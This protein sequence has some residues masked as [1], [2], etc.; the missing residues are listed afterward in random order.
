MKKLDQA[1]AHQLYGGVHKP[2]VTYYGKDLFDYALMIAV[3]ATIVVLAYGPRNVMMYVGVALCAF[4]MASFPMRHGFEPKMPV[5]LRRPQEIIYMFLYKLQNLPV[6]YFIAIA[7]LL[8]QHFLVVAT[9]N[10]PHKVEMMRTI[11]L[12]LFYAHFLIVT[13]YR[14]TILFTHLAKKEFAREVLMQTPWK[15][16][17]NARTNITLEIFHAWATGMLTHLILITPWFI[18]MKYAKFSLLFAP[19]MI[20]V[21]VFVHLKWLKATNAWFYRDHW[22]G[23]NSEFEFIYLHGSHHDAIPCALIGVAGNG[24]LEGWFRGTMAFPIPFYNPFVPF[25]IYSY[26]IKQDMDLHQYIPGIYPELPKKVVEIGQ[27][28]THH[29]GRL[30]P[31]TIAIKVDQ[32]HVPEAMKNFYKSPKVAPLFP[33]ELMNSLKLD[34]E[35]NGFQWDNPTHKNTLTLWDKYSMEAA[36]QN[37]PR[38]ES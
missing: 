20:A 23:H 8:A 28:S 30:E 31:Y 35:L 5:F 19:V 27:H 13:G 4:L 15:R 16:V 38:T 24:F 29:Y 36:K 11:G 33:D 12:W 22:L 2:R 37:S 1:A 34:E 21:N 10:L 7:V 3:T 18:V 9:P 32:P 6:P 14:T 25:L 26:E 17:I